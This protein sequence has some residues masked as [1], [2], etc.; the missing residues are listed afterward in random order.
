MF[1]PILRT[2]PGPPAGASAAPSA[3]GMSI[4]P[5]A[6]L[7]P[8]KR[9]PSPGGVA[10][11]D[12]GGLARRD[13]ERDADRSAC[14]VVEAGGLGVERDDA[15]RSRIVGDPAVE[16]GGVADASRRRRGRSGGADGVAHF[17]RWATARRRRGLRRAAGRRGLGVAPRL[18]SPTRRRSGAE[19]RIGL[20][21]S[22]SASSSRQALGDGAELHRE[23]ET[24]LVDRVA[25]QRLERRSTGTFASER[26]QLAREA[27]LVGVVDQGLAALGLLDLAGAGQQRVEVAD[28][29]GSAGRRS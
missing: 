7:P 23:E 11:R 9:S 10:E 24:S 8:P 20:E 15:R 21:A 13:A 6:A 28:I 1:W 2:E 27:D 18:S 22:A 17:G 14:M 4:W 12:V 5:S 3:V 29:R 25:G 19:L 26:H 16:R